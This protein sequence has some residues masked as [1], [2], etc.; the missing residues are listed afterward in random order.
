MMFS[1]IDQSPN[2]FKSLKTNN[3][4]S[5]RLRRARVKL[6]AG[7]FSIALLAA[8]LHPSPAYAAEKDAVSVWNQR[9]AVTLT[10][11]PAAAVPGV[12]FT[13]PV[14]FIHIAMVQ[15]AVYDA[16]NA[17]KGGHDP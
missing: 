11:G 15:G 2:S 17:I 7:L 9:A 10:N 6:S 16:V 1:G 3:K 4:S 8:S 12:Q 13:P 5:F 14:A